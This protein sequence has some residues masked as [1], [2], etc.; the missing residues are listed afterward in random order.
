MGLNPSPWAEQVK[1]SPTLKIKSIA[2]QL[3]REGKRVYDFGIGEMN[4]EIPVPHMLKSAIA[5]AVMGDATHYS[6]AA[7]DPELLQ[8]IHADLRLFGLNYSP[9]QIVVCPGPKDAVFKSCLTLLNPTAPRH[10]LVTFAPIYESYENIPI[11]L[12]G[13]PPIVL[14]T[15]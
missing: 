12:T 14:Q 13:K 11:L 6:P 3:R 2:D 10:R 8:A 9:S 7:G 1:P 4:P 15:D 5:E